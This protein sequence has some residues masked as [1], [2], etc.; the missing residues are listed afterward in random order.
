[1]RKLQDAARIPAKIKQ[2]PLS[3][4]H[5][6]IHVTRIFSRNHAARKLRVA[7]APKRRVNYLVFITEHVFHC[8]RDI[9]TRVGRR[10]HEFLSR[11][12]RWSKTRASA[13]YTRRQCWQAVVDALSRVNYPRAAGDFG[14]GS[15]AKTFLKI[16]GGFRER[17]VIVLCYLELLGVIRKNC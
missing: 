9:Y 7:L 17:P 8:A 12:V 2:A 10:P 11:R 15:F 4:A 6:R 1:M 3:L 13:L 5:R 14:V 16:V